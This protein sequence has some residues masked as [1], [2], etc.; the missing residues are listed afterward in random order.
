MRSYPVRA[1]ALL[2]LSPT[3]TTR[4]SGAAATFWPHPE[5]DWKIVTLSRAS[6]PDRAPKFRRVLEQLGATGE[7]ADLDDEPG[8]VAVIN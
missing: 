2:L 4:H 3:R 6:D 8:Q 5:I 1:C 7:M